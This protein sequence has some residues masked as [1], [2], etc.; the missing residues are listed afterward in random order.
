MPTVEHLLELANECRD[1]AR[2]ESNPLAKAQFK[3]MGDD[4]RRQAE[5][6]KKRIQFAEQWGDKSLSYH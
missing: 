2:V 3:V 6:L 5:D 4:C 1:R